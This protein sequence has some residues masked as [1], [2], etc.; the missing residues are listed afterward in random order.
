MTGN[1]HAG[2]LVYIKSLLTRQVRQ[3]WWSRR[4]VNIRKTHCITF[5]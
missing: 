1:R 4:V 2:V 3:N 5:I